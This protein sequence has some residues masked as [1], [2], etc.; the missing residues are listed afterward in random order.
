LLAGL[1]AHVIQKGRFG[2]VCFHE[3]AGVMNALPPADEVQQ[4]VSVDA[5]GLV[6]QAADI[7][8]VQV[9]ID[10]ADF[11]PRGLL[12]HMNRTLCVRGGR[13]VDH[14]ELH[15]CAASRRDWN[16]RASPP[17]TKKELGS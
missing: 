3:V 17:W 10:P 5:E 12:D 16:C 9:T 4:V 2:K 7:F 13:Q 1:E 14:V 11:P 6:R 8:A 15:G